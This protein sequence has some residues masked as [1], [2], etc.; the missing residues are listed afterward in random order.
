MTKLNLS[1]QSEWTPGESSFLDDSSFSETELIFPSQDCTAET[2]N[3]AMEKLTT[4]LPNEK[5]R[6]LEHALN[7]TWE[8]ATKEEKKTCVETAKEGYRIICKVIAP[9]VSEELFQAV[10]QPTEDTTTSKLLSL[11]TSYAHLFDNCKQDW[12]TVASI[13]EDLLGKISEK[14][15]E[16]TQAVLRSDEAGCYHNNLLIFAIHDIN[17]RSKIKVSTYHFSEPQYG[18]DVCDRILCPLKSS[19]R[20]YCNEGNDILSARDMREALQER[21]SGELRHPLIW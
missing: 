17:K 15:P 12:Y 19:I 4:K 21:Q 3:E 20:R 5:F 2:N 18:K 6:P 11:I 8:N 16:I 9:H 13:L 1:E 7:K 14:N 10:K